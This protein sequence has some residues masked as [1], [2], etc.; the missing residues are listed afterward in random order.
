[1]LVAKY[2]LI[3]TRINISN[4]LSSKMSML[5]HLSIKN[6]LPNDGFSNQ[7]NQNGSSFSPIQ[8]VSRKSY[9]IPFVDFDALNRKVIKV[10]IM[11]RWFHAEIKNIFLYKCLLCTGKLYCNLQEGFFVWESGDINVNRNKHCKMWSKYKR[12][13]NICNYQLLA[14]VLL[15]D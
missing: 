13:E 12:C 3:F 9:S 2:S 14:V 10:L 11:Q 15:S 6:S 4:I 7:T 8:K 1:M 5:V